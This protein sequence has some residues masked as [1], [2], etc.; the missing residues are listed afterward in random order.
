MRLRAYLIFWSFYRSGKAVK[1]E[2]S[3]TPEIMKDRIIEALTRIL[4]KGSQKRPLILAIEDLHW[5]D[6]S[7]EEAFKALLDTI[8]GARVFII[9]TYRPEYVHTWGG[10]SYHSQVNLNRLSNRQSLAMA[11][12]F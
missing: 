2:R 12:I 6:K 9:F 1:A 11:P 3:V 10:K 4:I 7:S 8:S 5:V